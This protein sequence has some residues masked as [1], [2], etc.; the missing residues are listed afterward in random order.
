M[1]FVIGH[2]T[3]YIPEIRGG[4]KIWWVGVNIV[5][6][7]Q[8]V[9]FQKILIL[10][11]EGFFHPPHPSE[12]SSKTL[13]WRGF[14][15]PCHPHWNLERPFMG[16]L[17]CF[18]ELDVKPVVQT[19]VRDGKTGSKIIVHLVLKDWCKTSWKVMCWYTTHIQ[20]CLATNQLV[21]GCTNLLQKVESSSFFCDK[22]CTCC[23]F[24]QPKANLFCCKW[25]NSHVMAW[26]LCNFI[27]SEIRIHA[28]CNNLIC[29]Q[30]GLNMGGKTRN[31][32]FQHVLQQCCKTS[33]MFLL[34]ILPVA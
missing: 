3:I 4:G 32:A 33:C 7:T 25:R 15:T 8:I 21:A 1:S 30:T 6:Q 29:Y 22:I 19:T 2:Y 16:W 11:H 28:T 12:N 31:I 34:P 18:L 13:V 24:Y 9:S 10:S 26:L 27:Q 23:V 17:G 14:R 20:T 5:T